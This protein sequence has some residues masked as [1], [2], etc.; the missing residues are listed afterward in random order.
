MKLKKLRVKPR[1]S[2]NQYDVP[3]E[4]PSPQKYKNKAEDVIIFNIQ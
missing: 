1:Q 2:K 4:E 3:D